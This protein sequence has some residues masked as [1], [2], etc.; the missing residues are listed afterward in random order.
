MT[1]RLLVVVG[2]AGGLLALLVLLLSG[3]DPDDPETRIRAA[4]TEMARS[5]GEKN[6]AG[7]LGH[8]SE[9]FEGDGG[10]DRDRLRGLLFVELRRAGWTRVVLSDVDVV[11][12]SETVADVTLRAYLARGDGPIP[13]NADGWDLALTFREEGGDWKVVGGRYRSIRR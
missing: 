8:V 1:P 11:F 3:G 12:Q 10:L 4:L 7:I 6:P 2:L 13:A 9:G 5:A